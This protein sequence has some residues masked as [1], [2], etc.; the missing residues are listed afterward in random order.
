MH[1][2]VT[3]FL[4][5]LQEEVFMRSTVTYWMILQLGVCS[6][7]RAFGEPQARC[8]QDVKYKNNH[9]GLLCD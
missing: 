4:I 7:C 9:L 1:L 2:I 3:A 6:V 8:I 5:V